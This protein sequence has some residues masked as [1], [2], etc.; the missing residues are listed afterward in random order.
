MA[1]RERNQIVDIE[2]A[3]NAKIRALTNNAMLNEEEI[4][5]LRW[6]LANESFLLKKPYSEIKDPECELIAKGLELG[7]LLKRFPTLEH[8]RLVSNY[9]TAEIRLSLGT[10]VQNLGED[11][12]QLSESFVNEQV[13]DDCPLGFPL[14]TSLR[15]ETVGGGLEGNIE[16]SLE[17]WFGRALLE[18]AMVTTARRIQ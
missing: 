11:C 3:S 13:I 10:L 15:G 4:K 5:V 8:Y 7:G 18:R 2:I 6:V 1:C 12:K 14:L 17:D 16:R 9:V